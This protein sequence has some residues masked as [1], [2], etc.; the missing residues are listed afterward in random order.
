MGGAGEWRMDGPIGRWTAVLLLALLLLLPGCGPLRS[1]EVRLMERHAEESLARSEELIARLYRKNP[2][3]E[4]DPA[5]RQ[6]N[7]RR[8]FH[9]EHPPIGFFL[10]SSHEILAEAFVA[11][12]AEPDRVFLLGLGLAKSIREAYGLDRGGPFLLG[13]Q[14]SHERLERLHFNLNHLNWR[15]KNHR[16]ARGDLLFL[17]NEVGP[18]GTL[19][20][21][22]EVI[23]TEI[24]TW[25]RDDLYLR[26]GLPQRY[27][28]SM[29]TLFASI[30]L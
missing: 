26:G 13:L 7:L 25:I 29:T 20:M 24:L 17:T 19:N 14:V 8:I 1:T 2:R 30:V 4:K 11:S 15:I 28:F 21:G 27:I 12:P 5:I 23:M 3:Y 22:Y 9:E 10:K 6:R 16:D 18:D